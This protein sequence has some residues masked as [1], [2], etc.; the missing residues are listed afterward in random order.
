M[1][2][3]G[4][5][6]WAL[7]NIEE[8]ILQGWDARSKKLLYLF[9]D[10]QGAWAYYDKY[11]KTTNQVTQWRDKEALIGDKWIKMSLYYRIHIKF[12]SPVTY[13][14]FRFGA[15]SNQFQTYEAIV[16]ITKAV[17]DQFMELMGEHPN[18]WYKFE[19]KHLKKGDSVS[20]VA[21]VQ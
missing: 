14:V 10:D 21:F 16:L 17:Y 11:T 6:P 8:K 7:V 9:K 18:G 12:A 1:S 13:S 3:I 5:M 15:G 19:Y 4:E 2:E 20:K